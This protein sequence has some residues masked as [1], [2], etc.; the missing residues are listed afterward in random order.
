MLSVPDH[1]S[2]VPIM[3]GLTV[4]GVG[5]RRDI[6]M[7]RGMAIGKNRLRVAITNQGNGRNPPKANPGQKASGNAINKFFY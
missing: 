2:Q 6:P 1:H 5:V 3:Y 4:T 7:F